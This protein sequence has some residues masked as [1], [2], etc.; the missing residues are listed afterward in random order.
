MFLLNNYIYYYELDTLI[1]LF[2]ITILLF[3]YS[4]KK[5][6]FFLLFF[7]IFLFY[8]YR[9]PEINKN[10][11]DNFVYSPAYGRIKQIKKLDKYLQ[12]SIFINLT[13][14]HVQYIPYNGYMNKI[15]HKKGSFYPAYM[16]KKG[17]YNEKMVYSINTNKGLFIISQIA[18]I[19]TRTIIPFVKENTIVKQ[20]QE[21]GLIK[22][23]S[24]CDIFIPNN[25]PMKIL[26]KEGDKV[27]GTY[28]KL[29]EFL[30]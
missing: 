24:R 5:I 4:F 21:L 17:K 15:I 23:G 19:F 13:D 16:F 29:V 2:V 27:N 11:L 1:F 12:I 8:F 7:I 10:I 20:N 25:N 9:I 14:P 28:T 26:V 6:S 30:N 18:G 3:K 22:I